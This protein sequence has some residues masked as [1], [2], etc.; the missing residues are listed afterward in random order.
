VNRSILSVLAVLTLLL[1]PVTANAASPPRDLVAVASLDGEVAIT[2][3]AAPTSETVRDAGAFSTTMI[4]DYGMVG[5]SSYEPGINS[6]SILVAELPLNPYE[7]IC[8]YGHGY[9]GAFEGAMLA[10]E[11]ELNGAYV[12]WVMQPIS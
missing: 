5:I 2:F 7:T 6:E 8:I 9:D 12:H 10:R 4:R 3:E 1:V 11:I